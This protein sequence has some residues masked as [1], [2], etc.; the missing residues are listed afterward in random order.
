MGETYA[1]LTQSKVQ[2]RKM[3]EHTI[4]LWAMEHLLTIKVKEC[5]V[6]SNAVHAKSTLTQRYSIYPRIFWAVK[7][8]K[9][10]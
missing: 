3:S 10:C 4:Q 8:D 5:S 6:F 1:I 7:D 9:V 2:N